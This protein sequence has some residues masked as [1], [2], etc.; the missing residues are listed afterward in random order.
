[1]AALMHTTR[2][3]IATLS[4]RSLRETADRSFY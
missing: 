1:M 4:T 2:I 3:L